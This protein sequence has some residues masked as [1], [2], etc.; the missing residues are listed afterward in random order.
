MWESA[1]IRFCGA[2]IIPGMALQNFKYSSLIL[3]STKST[4]SRVRKLWSI[5]FK[6]CCLST[7]LFRLFGIFYNLAA[8]VFRITAVFSGLTRIFFILYG[9]IFSRAVEVFCLSAIL[10]CIYA[11]F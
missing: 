3:I 7:G 8:A 6:R 11:V 5:S 2:G 1:G 9:V 10:F 4:L